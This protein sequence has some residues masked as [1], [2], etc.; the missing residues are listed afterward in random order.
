M[1][2][3]AV[4]LLLGL[5]VPASA[6]DYTKTKNPVVLV[7][8]LF[9]FDEL[10]GIYDY[11]YDIP[12]QLRAGGAKVYVANVSS[13]NSSEL[14]GE[15]LID[16][17]ETLQATYGYGRFNLVGHSHGGPTARY[18]A[19][20]RPD[21]VASVTSMGSPHTGSRVADGLGTAFPPGSPGRALVAGLADALGSFLEFLSGDDD[22]QD[23]LAALTSL[24]GAGAAAFNA[25]YP[26]G[27]PAS[28]CGQGASS[29]RGVRYY[30]M[31]GTTPLTNVFDPSDL[32]MGAGALF[33]GF[34]ANDGLVGRCSS[35]LGSVIRDD[36]AWN[37][38]DEV[39][40][41]AGLRGLFA[42]SPPSVYRA[43]LNRL[44]NAGL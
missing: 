6:D 32:L 7:H 35:H 33:F 43:H 18:V 19:S 38:L 22:P 44:K 5:A 2:A 28:A 4:L 17:L 14:R 41:V 21:L 23:A 37:H 25:R 31:G 3:L 20:V 16:Y 8:G 9:G 10:G 13:A 40:Q 11:W 26:E 30:S 34:E 12:S 29:V 39:N 36:Y 1:R 42:S 24:N 15:Q 27:M